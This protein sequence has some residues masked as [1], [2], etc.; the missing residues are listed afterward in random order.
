MQ[1]NEFFCCSSSLVEFLG[2]AC[3]SEI[4]NTLT[5]FF[6]IYIHLIFFSCLIALDD[7]SIILLSRYGESRSL[8]LILD[9]SGIAF[10]QLTISTG[11]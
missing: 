7:S 9:F 1:V 3:A 5:S 11:Q 10:C 2:V 8:C 6:P 4:H